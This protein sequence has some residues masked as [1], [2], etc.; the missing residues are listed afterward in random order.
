[1]PMLAEISRLLFGIM[2]A[3][4]HRP[5]ADFMLR[6]E[7]VLVVMFRQHGVPYPAT[8]TTEFTRNVYF[9]LGI[10]LSMFEMVRIWMMLHPTAPISA[11]FIR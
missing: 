1:M 9:A 4:F 8:P 2:I 7:R 6:Q 10:L 5:F 3:L 11:F